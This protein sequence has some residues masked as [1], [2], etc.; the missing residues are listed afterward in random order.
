MCRSRSLASL[1]IS[2]PS[3]LAHVEHHRVLAQHL[4][5][6]RRCRP[7]AFAHSMM[8][9]I[10]SQPRPRPFEVRAQED[11]VFG[12]LVV[13]VG[14]EAHDADHLAGRLVERH[15]GDG[16][17]VVDLDQPREEGM[18]ELA[19]RREEA[20]TQVLVAD[21]L[22]ELEEQPLVLGPHRADEDRAARSSAS[23]LRSHSLG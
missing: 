10:S 5:L 17:R 20:Q 22:E 16:A 18:A 7:S 13:R 6:D 21:M 14:M 19:H 9:C 3:A 4:A 15:E 12:R 2:N 11:R 8:S 23:M 1:R